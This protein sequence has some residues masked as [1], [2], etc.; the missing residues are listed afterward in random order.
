[1]SEIKSPFTTFNQAVEY[2]YTR[3]PLFQ[4]QGPSAY[5]PDLGN[6]RVLL[7]ALGDPHVGIRYVH[8]GG[9]NGKGSS[10]HMLAAILQSAGY[11]TG[12][13]TSPH[14]KSFTE[15]IRVNG[16]PIPEQDVVELLSASLDT[17][18]SIQPSFFEVTTTMA[19]QYF[20]RRKVDVAVIEVGLGGRLDATNIITP[21]VSLITNIGHDHLDLLGPGLE[22]VAFEKAGI[23]KK[24][25][26]VVISERQQDLEKVFIAKA[27]NENAE[28]IFASDHLEVS[29]EEDRWV[30][31]YEEKKIMVQPQLRGSY[32]K[33]NIAGVVRVVEILRKKGFV[34]SDE[35]LIAGI[36]NT[37]LLTGLKGRWQVLQ[38]NPKVICDTGHNPEGIQQILEQL[39]R[40]QYR[41]L[42][43]VFGV[44]GDK[45]AE[46]VL[47][48]LPST[49]KYYFCAARIPRAMPAERLSTEAASLGLKG[50]AYA[51]VQT[52]LVAARKSA[53]A[54][55]LIL[56]G[57]STY[58]VAEVEGL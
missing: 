3:L 58:V 13:Y 29:E 25:V 19:F 14:L 2:L 33:K 39:S 49:A 43:W 24:K 56:V 50:E 31:P 47:K 32:Q 40:E 10:S 12:L 36:E 55:D 35:A 11:K 20:Q 5:K 45:P 30:F 54:D 34:V 18:D 44:V 8:V 9:T 53:S 17:I 15:R 1:L 6:I 22:Q 26:P 21:V 41:Q 48:L 52:A 27:Q 38:L 37:S 42:H 23:I 28:L 57:G 51:D 46:K 7:S 16:V 4:N